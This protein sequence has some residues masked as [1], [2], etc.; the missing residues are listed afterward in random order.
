MPT[1]QVRGGGEV[2]SSFPGRPALPPLNSRCYLRNRHERVTSC[3]PGLFCHGDMLLFPPCAPGTEPRSCG[4][5]CWLCVQYSMCRGL[6]GLSPQSVSLPIPTVSLRG[7]VWLAFPS[8][9]IPGTR[10]KQPARKGGDRDFPTSRSSA[11]LLHR[12]LL[13]SPHMAPVD[14]MMPTP[15]T[16]PAR[17][18]EGSKSLSVASDSFS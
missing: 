8:L 3:L 6:P 9:P 10:A 2:C 16:R 13:R 17:N 7:R 4:K 11:S 5:R 1:S 15:P 18:P 12:P 14:A